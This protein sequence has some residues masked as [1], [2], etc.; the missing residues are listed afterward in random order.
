MGLRRENSLVSKLRVAVSPS[1]KENGNLKCL[2]NLKASPS[3]CLQAPSPC[4]QGLGLLTTV[5]RTKWDIFC[6][7]SC[8]ECSICYRL[9]DR[10]KHHF[11]PQLSSP[12]FDADFLKQYTQVAI[13]ARR[14][15]ATA[16][17][18][19]IMIIR[20][21]SCL[22]LETVRGRMTSTEQGSDWPTLLLT[23]QVR[24]SKSKVKNGVTWE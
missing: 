2:P 7:L 15:M 8:K 17:A 21:S 22:I 5:I 20:S 24:S 12:L 23:W 9:T 6:I 13:E 19:M 4:K 10:V 1:G 11:L 16:T 18:E 3:S 14:R